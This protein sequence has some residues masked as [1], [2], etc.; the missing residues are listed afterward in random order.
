MFLKIINFPLRMLL[1]SFTF[2]SAPDT[3][4]QSNREYDIYACK[5]CG[6]MFVKE[7]SRKIKSRK[8]KLK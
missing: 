5:R 2:H 6:N 1:C 3:P 7:S 8:R 4:V